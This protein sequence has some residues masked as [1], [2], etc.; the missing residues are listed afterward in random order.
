M[1]NQFLKITT[2]SLIASSLAFAGGYKIPETS[3][4][5][6][7]LGAANIAHSISADAAYSNPANMAFMS[8]TNAVEFDLM[9]IGLDPTNF[10]GSGAMAG[11]DIDAESESFL[12]PSLNYVSPKLGDFRVG[13]SVGVPGGLTKRWTDSPAIDS[14]EE[15]SLTV[16]EVNPTLA[17][18][19]NDQLSVAVGA[20][21]VHSEG[22]VKST[23]VASR[24]MEANS[25]DFGYNLAISYKPMSALELAL[26]YRSNVDLTEEGNGKLL[27][28]DA[29]VYDGGASVSVPLPALLNLAVAYTFPTKT[30][31]EFVYERAFWSAYEELDFD[32]KST[33]PGLLQP[34]FDAPVAKDWEDTNA[35]R[36][37]VTQELNEYTLMAGL[38]IDT[39][40][41][42]DEKVS[43]ELPDSDSVAI[44]FG[45]RYQINKDLDFGLAMLYS[46]RDERKVSNDE[47]EGEFSNSNV[48]IASV[49]VGY[50]F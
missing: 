31:V 42:P 16:I 6:V 38:V 8:D 39:T 29:K 14:A 33:I 5:A 46:M 9:Y 17:Y 7:A 20:R 25:L 35:F 4:N 3:T 48:F 24:D 22:V 49:G 18:K 37:G 21:L 45:G 11:I 13:L 10:K 44:S 50:K 36:I 40:P 34:S 19:I 26:T 30:T 12:I 27:I 28:G 43:F 23:S 41:V 32:Y 15:F 47:M 2:L 1:K